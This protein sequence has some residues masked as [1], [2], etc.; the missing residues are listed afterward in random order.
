[1]KY[2]QFAV[3]DKQMIYNI[4]QVINSIKMILFKNDMFST[5]FS[6]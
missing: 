4:L 3:T 5:N 1:M 6:L 2:V